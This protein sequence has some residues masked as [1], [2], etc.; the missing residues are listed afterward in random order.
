MTTTCTNCSNTPTVAKGLCS[1][2]Y[3]R[4]R[5]GTPLSTP[6][7]TPRG[8]GEQ[9][10]LRCSSDQLK[11]WERAAKKTKQAFRDWIRNTL[12]GASK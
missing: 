9:I 8:E 2:C 3:K 12:D 11:A 4:S 7:R 10:A 6:E 5:R 1:R